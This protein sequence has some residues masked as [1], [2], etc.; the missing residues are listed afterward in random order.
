MS[1]FKFH[2]RRSTLSRARPYKCHLTYFYV[3]FFIF[4]TFWEERWWAG[5]NEK[6]NTMNQ[7]HEILQTILQQAQT[8]EYGLGKQQEVRRL[9]L[10][11]DLQEFQM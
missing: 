7:R 4:G 8:T 5:G 2:L 9:K 3:N 11:N 6:P 10:M 1:E